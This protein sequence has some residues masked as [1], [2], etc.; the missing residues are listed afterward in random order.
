MAI[1]NIKSTYSLDIESV[2]VLEV[3][4]QRWK[5]SKSEVLRRAIRLAAEGGYEEYDSKLNALDQLQSCVRER[6]IDLSKWANEIK[7]ERQ[8]RRRWDPLRGE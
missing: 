4:A 8:A 5:V 7:S 1:P 6:R 3:L 2:R